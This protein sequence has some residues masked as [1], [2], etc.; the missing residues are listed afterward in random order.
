MA[1]QTFIGETLHCPKYRLKPFGNLVFDDGVK[2]CV[3]R[4]IRKFDVCCS[5]MSLSQIN[6]YLFIE[7]QPFHWIR[8]SFWIIVLHDS[9]LSS[10]TL[11]LSGPRRRA[12]RLKNE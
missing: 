5:V 6:T 9:S 11:K 3:Q 12:Q 1:R 7:L 8:R 2:Q 4:D 10:L